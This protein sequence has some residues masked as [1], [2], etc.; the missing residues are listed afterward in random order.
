MASRPT[1][2]EY[3]MDIAKLTAKRSTCD[4]A[5]VGAVAVKD[6]RIIMSGYNGSPKGLAHCTEASHLMVE[7]HCIRTVHAEQNVITQCAKKGISL[8]RATIY[9]THFPCM[10]CCKLLLSAGVKEVLYDQIYGDVKNIFAL[11]LKTRQYL[12]ENDNGI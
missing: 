12:E 5:M 6:N 4:R 7:G 1:R 11:H 2:D 9:V 8:E 10:L 3:F